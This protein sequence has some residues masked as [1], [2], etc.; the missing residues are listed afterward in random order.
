MSRRYIIILI[1][2]VMILPFP[3]TIVP[4][5]KLKVI[6]ENGNVCPNKE[7]TQTWAHYSIY[8]GSGNF[9]SEDRITN[10][11]GFV[12]FPKRTVW[13]PLIWRIIGTIVAKALTMAHGS[14]GADSSV[15]SRGIKDV[16]WI[17]Y[18]P[19]TP[20]ADKIVVRSCVDN[21]SY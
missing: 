13:A 19:D 16:A 12:E 1:I 7:V 11:E 18:K 2:A 5:W 10:E 4:A 8:I 6:D 20:L 21:E 17:S 14:E 15:Y 3:I 9:Q